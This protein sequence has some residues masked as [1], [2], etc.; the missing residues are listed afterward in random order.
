MTAA[1]L[2]VRE[3]RRYTALDGLFENVVPIRL[4]RGRL[5]ANS[6]SAE[7]GRYDLVLAIHSVLGPR[8][9][10][11]DRSLQRIHELLIEGGIVLATFPAPPRR[12]QPMPMRLATGGRQGATRLHE[13]EW[14]YRLR[15]AGFLGVRLRRFEGNLDHAAAILCMAV[16]RALN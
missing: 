5:V 12:L 10:D 11:V 3:G 1:S 4:A 7:P 15:R 8:L 2:Y 6:G 13:L 16:R 9:R 14:N